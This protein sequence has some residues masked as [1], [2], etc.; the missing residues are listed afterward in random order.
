MLPSLAL[1]SLM[2]P[3]LTPFPSQGYFPILSIEIDDDIRLTLFW[4]ISIALT[5]FQG[6]TSTWWLK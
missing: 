5:L 6:Y 3:S 2:Q 1:L 4:F